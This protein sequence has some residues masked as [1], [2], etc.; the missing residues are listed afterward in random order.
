MKTKIF[1]LKSLGLMS[2]LVMS[3]TTHAAL[4]TGEPTFTRDKNLA[5]SLIFFDDVSSTLALLVKEKG[6][7]ENLLQ[8]QIQAARKFASLEDHTTEHDVIPLISAGQLQPRTSNAPTEKADPALPNIAAKTRPA[9][10]VAPMRIKP[11]SL[12]TSATPHA[13]EAR[14]LVVDAQMLNLGRIVPISNAVA[15]WSGMG[16]KLNTSASATGVIKSPYPLTKSQRF[17]VNAE[18]YVPAIGYAVRG[19]VAIAPLYSAELVKPLVETFEINTNHHIVLGKALNANLS[20]IENVRVEVSQDEATIGYSLGKMGLFASGLSQSGPA[21]DFV[22]IGLNS[23]IQYFMP[24]E[25]NEEWASTSIDLSGAPQIVSIAL[26]RAEKA[27]AHTNVVDAFAEELPGGTVSLNVGGQRG[28]YLPEQT[29][30]TLIDENGAAVLDAHGEEIVVN[31]LVDDLYMRSALDLF[32]VRA[33]SYLKT[34]VSNPAMPNL[35]ARVSPL[36]SEGQVQTLLDPIGMFWSSAQ[37]FV[38]GTLTSPE[39][40]NKDLKIAVLGSD[41]K[42]AK[43]ATVLYF[44]ANNRITTG[45]LANATKFQPRFSIVGLEPGE[46]SVV[47]VDPKGSIIKDPKTGRKKSAPAGIATTVMRTNDGVLSYV[48]I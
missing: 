41:G 25:G 4:L 42:P 37:S 13:N 48:E 14:V 29:P 32:E 47:V 15:T 46:W 17:I 38:Y 9:V 10:Q 6:I 40:L 31:T 33:P 34:W 18:G 44:D 26:S 22:A 28:V 23:S 39:L 35:V 12:P 45:D 8:T 36:L 27:F 1:S 16:S 24:T 30:E 5:A 20:P 11:N 19:G 21:G 43:N 7:S 3:P 2:L